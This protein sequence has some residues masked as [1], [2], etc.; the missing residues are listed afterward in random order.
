M[1]HFQATSQLISQSFP[2][3]AQ[4]STDQIPDM[5]GKIV[6]VTGANTGLYISRLKVETSSSPRFSGIGKETAKALLEHNAQVYIAVRNQEKA[7]AAI[8]D[9]REQ[10]GREAHFLKLDLADLTSVK[11]AVEDFLR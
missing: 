4:W 3:K 7:V 9:L 11:A 2:P 8:Q 10:T 6:I 5:T 1:T